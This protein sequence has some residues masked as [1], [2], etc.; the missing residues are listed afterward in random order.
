[1]SPSGA[2]RAETLFHQ[3]RS[4][5]EDRRADFLDGACGNDLALR[6]KVEALLKADAEAGSF[7]ASGSRGA[8]VAS[9]VVPHEQ[10]GARI[11]R[12]KL[13]QQI[14]EGGFGAAEWGRKRRYGRE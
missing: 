8:G 10:A 3:A 2:R 11:G 9:E 6:T 14:G 7:L 13:L 5:P 1:M 4:R 12:Y